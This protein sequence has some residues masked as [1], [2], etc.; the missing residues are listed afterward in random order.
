MAEVILTADRLT[1]AE[2]K[3]VS[4]DLIGEVAPNFSLLD[5]AGNVFESSTLD[6]SWRI[7]FF[8]AKK[9]RCGCSKIDL[10]SCVFVF[11]KNHAI[12]HRT[13]R[14]LICHKTPYRR[15]VVAH[16]LELS[17]VGI[18]DLRGV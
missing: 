1:R 17:A 8:Y 18:R 7:V 16:T 12:A 2:A 11:P 3:K 9:N 4:K 6:G 13:T 15:S 14:S 10:L 5:D